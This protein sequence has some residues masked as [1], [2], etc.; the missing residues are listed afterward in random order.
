MIERSQDVKVCRSQ[1][2][3]AKLGCH[4][5]LPA[6]HSSRIA[7][8]FLCWP[9]HEP[10]LH[11]PLHFKPATVATSPQSSGPVK[12]ESLCI[13]KPLVQPSK[14]P[15]FSANFQRGETQPS[16]AGPEAHKLRSGSPTTSRRPFATSPR[17]DTRQCLM[18]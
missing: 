3:Y 11:F 18:C 5:F 1:S 15:K 14:G 13:P 4:M 2:F 7:F 9:F 17:K 10:S 6:S 12:A 16:P 8:C